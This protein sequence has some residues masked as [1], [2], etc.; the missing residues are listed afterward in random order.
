MSI[1][2]SAL[3]VVILV[4]A[5][6]AAAQAQAPAQV[7]AFAV[8]DRLPVSV[9]AELD[10]LEQ[11]SLPTQR[12]TNARPTTRAGALENVRRAVALETTPA[13]ARS[14]AAIVEAADVRGLQNVAAELAF[15]NRTAAAGA[16]LLHAHAAA[17][18]DPVVLLNLANV[19]VLSGFSAEALAILDG[20]AE[21]PPSL[22]AMTLA[23]RGYALVTLGRA[24]E[25]EP[26]LRRALELDASIAE[27][28]RVLAY[29]LVKR[30]ERTE[31]LRILR[32]AG[33]PSGMQAVQ[34]RRASGQPD[35]A[36][37]QMNLAAVMRRVRDA[38]QGERKPLEQAYDLS[39]G[40]AVPFPEVPR[41]APADATRLPIDKLR[42]FNERMDAWNSAYRPTWEALRGDINARH[43]SGDIDPLTYALAEEVLERIDA[44]LDWLNAG[45]NEDAVVEPELI[46]HAEALRAATDALSKVQNQV[47]GE[48]AQRQ[49]DAIPAAVA[50]NTCQPIADVHAWATGAR[51]PAINAYEKALA[52]WWGY[53]VPRAT[54]LVG[55]LKDPAY[56]QL[57]KQ[58]VDGELMA[59]EGTLWG[60]RGYTY[61]EAGYRADCAELLRERAAAEAA[62][63]NQRVKAGPCIGLTRQTAKASFAFVEASMNCEEVSLKLDFSWKKLSDFMDAGGGGNIA[64]FDSGLFAEGKW[65]ADGTR[66]LYAG[67]GTS[68]SAG[69]GSLAG[70]GASAHTGIFVSANSG[71]VTDFGIRAGAGVTGS[72]AGM[73][74]GM[75]GSFDIS[76]TTLSGGAATL[77]VMAGLD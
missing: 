16:L 24:T 28:A 69:M 49:M 10:R 63:E 14:L 13:N 44:E 47:T 3:T 9:E 15:G 27:A 32:A 74:S 48:S 19:L 67:F 50:A 17:P 56:H 72:V 39:Q 41:V 35:D 71:G 8:S 65:Q 33:R 54:G 25:A 42:L 20:T 70:V 77:I 40:H 57:A 36:S 7:R 22:E 37:G 75:G 5:A 62:A 21:Q 4:A 68:A 11:A 23:T 31:A 55:N 51:N 43:D 60:A 29:V 2:L 64:D 59:L 18:D 1:R 73:E 38:G 66:T 45:D 53:V 6:A 46:R 61:A 34:G 58:A 26:L 30:G 12:S 52:D 76:A